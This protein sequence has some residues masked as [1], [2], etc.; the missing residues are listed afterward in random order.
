[1]TK[2][3][4]KALEKEIEMPFVKEII[5]QQGITPAASPIEIEQWP[6]PVK[7]YTLGRFEI[8]RNQVPLRFKG[9]A[10]QKP[11]AMLKALIALG[12]RN[13]SEFQLAEALWPDADG[14]MQLQ[15]LATTLHRLRKVMGEKDMIEYQDSHLSINARYAWVDVWAFERL[16]SQAESEAEKGGENSSFFAARYAE[17]AINFYKGSFLPQNSMDYWSIHLRERLKSRFLRGVVFLGRNLEKI[18]ERD[19]AI[20]QYLRALEIDPLVEEFY[21]RLM[22]CYHRLGRDADA[23][24][25]FKSCEKNLQSMLNVEPSIETEAIMKNLIGKSLVKSNRPKSKKEK[26]VYL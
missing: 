10:Q 6:W 20:L 9:K 4:L 18:N 3:S 13:V 7:I 11:L 1:M 2:L 22:I 5:S 17:R 8:V 21:Q 23:V 26:I 19:K 24:R 15:S 14:D 25:I 12:G 16:L